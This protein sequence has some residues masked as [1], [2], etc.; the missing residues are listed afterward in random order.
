MPESPAFLISKQRREDAIN[1]LKFLRGKS[2]E[3]VQEEYDAIQTSVDEAM[4][5]KGSVRDV[6]TNKV[7]LKGKKNN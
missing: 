5:Q 4:K 2:E 6:V 7:N 1:A 3:G